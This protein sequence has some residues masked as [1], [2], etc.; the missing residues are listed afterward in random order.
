MALDIIM[1][2]E[3]GARSLEKK[4]EHAEVSSQIRRNT[5][6][7]PECI[8]LS[9]LANTYDTGSQYSTYP[10]FT[11]PI[12]VI[13]CR[14]VSWRIAFYS[15]GNI[16]QKPISIYRKVSSVC[17]DSCWVEERKDSRLLHV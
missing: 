2:R 17:R 9:L 8:S 7:F 6:L 13:I 3:S 15:D 11:L 4:R 1:R 16:S 10:I 12:S 14:Y 5:Y